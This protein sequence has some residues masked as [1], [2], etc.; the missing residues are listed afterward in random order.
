MRILIT[1]TQRRMLV[2]SLMGQKVKVYYN[3]HKHTFSVQK[4][5]LVVMHADYIKLEN[6]EFKVRPTGKEKVRQE[7]S[8]NVHAFVI[9]EL[10][11][12]CEYPCDDI[13]EEP[14]GDIITYDPYKYDSFV[15]RETEEPVFNAKEVDLINSKNKLF[16]IEQ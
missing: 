16:V 4:N 1:E 10:V 15:Y 5:G 8:K 6:V 3:L 7:K 12:F 9:G 13:P 11:D 14:T 2:D